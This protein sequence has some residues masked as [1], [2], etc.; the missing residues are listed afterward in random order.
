MKIVVLGSTGMLGHKM[1]E[2]LQLHY[3][4]VRGISREDGLDATNLSSTKQLLGLLRPN[5]VINCVGVIK[6]RAQNPKESIAVNA[7]FP[8]ALNDICSLLDAN[9]IHFSTDCV[10]SGKY[11]NYREVSRPDPIDLYGITKC[12]GE[13]QDGNALTLRTSII[14]R[15]RNNYKGLLE[16]FL[17]RGCALTIGY[18]NAI[19]SGV[20]T[21]WLSDTIAALLKKKLPSGLYQIA[22]PPI[23]KLQLLRIFNKVYNC[24]FQIFEG[25][26][27]ENCDRSLIGDK[28]QKYTGITTPYLDELIALQYEQDKRSG[29]AF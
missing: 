19:W 15:E 13:V 18:R 25:D 12:L 28:F 7:R 10:F 20:T 6:Q 26:L 9:L 23:S 24:G 2:R 29:Y 17:R 8:H 16:W 1:V 3:P 14:G 22:A 27:P 21:N 4:D 11:G 5:I